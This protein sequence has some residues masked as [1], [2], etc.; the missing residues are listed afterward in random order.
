M[1]KEKKK[2]L[3][4]RDIPFNLTDEQYMLT[5]EDIVLYPI[6]QRA[7]EISSVG[8]DLSA[9]TLSAQ[10]QSEKRRYERQQQ[11]LAKRN[12]QGANH[13]KRKKQHV[14]QE[15]PTM[16]G[17]D[18]W[19]TKKKK[20]KNGRFTF[21]MFLQ[22]IK[23]LFVCMFLGGSIGNKDRIYYSLI[24]PTIW[25][26]YIRATDHIRRNDNVRGLIL[27]RYGGYGNQR[28]QVGFSGDVGHNWDLFSFEPY[29]TSTASNVGYGYWSHD[30]MFRSL[31]SLLVCLAFELLQI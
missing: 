10:A 2:Q 17:F 26:N 25:L 5:L 21:C 14:T 28:Y 31:F 9:T 22:N 30:I 15:P 23:Y 20:K 6:S 16:D 8:P 19:L 27:A 12:A 3:T 24:N 18:F 11:V 29:F 7:N 13:V 4:N 1:E